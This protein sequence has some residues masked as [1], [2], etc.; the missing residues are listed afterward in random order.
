MTDISMCQSTTCKASDTCRRHADSGTKP[1]PR[2][3]TYADFEPDSDGM[4]DAYWHV[5]QMTIDSDGDLD[6]GEA[7]S[8]RIVYKRLEDMDA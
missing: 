2:W 7:G 3:Q 6:P 4:C 5:N 1:E 8:G